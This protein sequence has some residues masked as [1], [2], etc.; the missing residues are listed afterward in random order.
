MMISL[1]NDYSEGCHPRILDAMVRTNMEQTDGY[2]SDPYTAE[3]CD[4]L[5]KKLQCPQADIHLFVSGTITNA[6]MIAQMLRPYESVISPHTGHICTQETGAV[7]STGHKTMPVY[8]PDGKLTP[9]MIEDTIY[10]HT[11]FH[12]VIPKLAYITNP[13]EIGTLYTKEELKAL[14]ETCKKHNMYLYLDGARMGSALTSEA[15]DIAP[16]DYAKYCDAFYFGGTKCGALF[17]EALIIVNPIFKENFMYMRKQM[18]SVLAKG[19]LLGIQFVELMKD[20][21][22]EE[23]G[24]HAN[25]LSMKIKHVIE[26]CGFS[27]LQE[28][29]TNQQFPILPNAMVEEL[30]KKYKMTFW[31]RHG[32]DHSVMRLVTCWATREENVDQFIADF[33]EIAKNYPNK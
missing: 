19:R 8:S 11:D 18:G 6:T 4:L 28:S 26:E 25:K 16:E 32:D 1:K 30:G 33:R 29:F 3:A 23:L 2:G 22:Y 15:N 12:R 24:A 31:D 5:R 20:G 7:E 9:Q 13:T 17:G 10:I 27:V 14:S 21:L